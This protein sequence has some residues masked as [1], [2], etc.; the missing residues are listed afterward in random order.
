MFHI[1]FLEGSL[2]TQAVDDDRHVTFRDV[3][4]IGRSNATASLLTW[5]GRRIPLEHDSVTQMDPATGKE[6]FLFAFTAFGAGRTAMKVTGL[7][8]YRF[9]SR[10][11]RRRAVQLAIEALLYYYYGEMARPWDAAKIRV[12][13]GRRQWRITDFHYATGLEEGA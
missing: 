3:S 8:V 4:G 7:P 2:L 9:S 11:E 13:E 5:E 12:A 6:Y 10:A 1:E